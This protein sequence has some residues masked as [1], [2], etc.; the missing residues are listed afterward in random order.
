MKIT[1]LRN[2]RE[3]LDTKYEEIDTNDGIYDDVHSVRNAL[4]SLGYKVKELVVDEEIKILKKLKT[5]LVFNLCDDFLD[6]MKEAVVPLVLQQKNI[7]YTGSGSSSLLITANKYLAK[8]KFLQSNIPTPNFQLFINS[9]QRLRSDL[10]FPLIVKPN[11]EHGSIGITARAVVKN[12]EEL[13]KR[14]RFIM[15]EKCNALV[16]EYIDGKEITVVLIGKKNPMV[17]PVSEIVFKG[18]ENKPKIMSYEAKWVKD[19]FAY[20]QTFRKTPADITKAEEKEIIKQCKKAY[21]AIGCKGYGRVDLR[22]K[23]GIPYILEVNPNPD[24]SEDAALSNIARESGM[25][26]NDLIKKII[27]LAIKE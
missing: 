11:N 16:E 15:K 14:I 27:D 2:N 7:K 9:N 19:D 24:L 20:Q 10:K 17:L 18:F 8:L 23:N 1:I 22:L 21:K 25:T 26:Y 3:V 13:Y 4:I 5:D 12:E 6:P